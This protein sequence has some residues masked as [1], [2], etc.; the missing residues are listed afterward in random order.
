MPKLTRFLGLAIALLALSSCIALAQDSLILNDGIVNSFFFGGGSNHITMTMPSFNCSA[1]TCFLASAGATGTGDLAGNGT[2]AI[3][4]PGTIPV[5]G[6]FAG[7]FSLTVQADGSS[8]VVQTAP[9]A[10]TYTSAQGDL[11]GTMTFTSVSKT[12]MINSTMLGTFQATGGSFAS[13][14]PN[15]AAVSIDLGITFPL[16]LFPTTHHAFAAVEFQSGSL[17]ANSVNGCQPT[18]QLRRYRQGLPQVFSPD[19][20][21]FFTQTNN[22]SQIPCSPGTPCGSIDVAEGSGGFTGDLV[23]TVNVGGVEGLQVDRMGFN[24]DVHSGFSLVCFNFDSSCSSGVGGASLG[25]SQQED[26]FGRF[27]NTLLTGLNG[28]SG[29]SPDGTGCQGLFTAVI[30]NS[31]GPLHESDFS[32][33]VAAHVANGVCTGYIAT[34]RN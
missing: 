21:A 5:Q 9:I 14:F 7:P 17:V 31:N 4:A 15:G 11:T 1:G 16:Q 3:T 12:T 10:F 18:N 33:Y 25:G 22:P 30:G 8:V 20:A 29:C 26:G 2:Y 23:V 28:G 24:S 32:S 6:G 13:F 27:A 19:L 34:P